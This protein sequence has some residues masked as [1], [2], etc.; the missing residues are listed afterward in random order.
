M[1]ISRKR[2]VITRNNEEEIFC[3]LA[4][5]YQFKAIRDIGDTAIKTYLSRKKA[6]SAFESSWD[7]YDDNFY[8]AIEVTESILSTQ[9]A[10]QAGEEK[11]E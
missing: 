2:W 1:N 3:G 10:A 4:R 6:I 5:A 7:E 8:K 9:E 11:H